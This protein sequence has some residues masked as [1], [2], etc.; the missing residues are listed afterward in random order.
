MST[1]V[2]PTA[3]I[4]E[5]VTLGEDTKIWHFVHVSEDARIGARCSIGQN[6]FVGR[7]V[8]IGDGVRVQN[9]VSLYEGVEVAD[10]AFLGP[11]CVF[12]NVVNPRSFVSRKHAYRPTRVGRGASI[13][14]NAV[15]VCGHDI[16]EYAF[17]GAGAVVTKD[18]PPYAL[19]VGNPARRIGWMSRAGVRLPEGTDVACP[20]TGERYRVEGERCVPVDGAEVPSGPVQLLDLDAQNGPLRPAIEAAMRGVIAK[21]QFIMGPDVA[22]FEREVAA[23]LGVPHAV[24][25]SSGTDALLV[26]LMALDIGPGDEVITTPFSFFATAGVI[27]RLGATPV[28]VDIDPATFNLDPACVAAKI[29]ERTR[30]ILPVHLFGQPCDMAGLRAVAPGIPIVEDAAQ[31]ILADTPEGPVGGLGELACFSFFPSKNLGCFGDGGLVTTRDEAFAE[32]VRRLRVHGSHPKYYHA[33]VGGNFRLDTL[34][35]AVLR[36]KLPHL[37]AWTEARRANAARYDGLFAAAGLPA[38]AVALPARVAPGHVYNQYTIRTARRDELV[39]HLNAHGIGNAIYYP[40]PLHLQGCFAHLGHREGDFP[41][42]ERASREVV[43]IPIY[44]EL[45][46]ARQRHV[47]DVIAQFFRV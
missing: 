18:V 25:V 41:E 7:G 4:D 10:D 32:R 28:F 2:H 45:G 43:S 30:A 21:N 36:V 16:G 12:T 22:A 9:N 24:G 15:I 39:K 23:M 11:S 6:C 44:A 47:V 27:H 42:S 20:E 40:L 26:A 46:E 1:Y 29:T 8:R 17:V 33:M 19:V 13:G 5:R 38:G 37:P 34:Q 31:T 14:A 35:A 3:V